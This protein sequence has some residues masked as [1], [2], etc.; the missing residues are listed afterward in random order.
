MKRL[1]LTLI[2]IF[3][4]LFST[5]GQQGFS[6]EFGKVWKADVEL[7]QYSQDKNAEAVVLF[8]VAT[9]HSERVAD[10]YEIVYE[11]TTR[12]KILSEAGIDWAE[13]E[14]PY[15]LEGDIYE[16]VTRIEAYSYIFENGHINKT[17][18]DISNVYTEKINDYWNVKKFAIPNVKPGSIIEYK[19]RINSQYMFNLRDWEF[20][21]KIPVVHSEYKVKLI[22]F[23][24]YEYI[25][26]GANKFD[27]FSSYLDK[28]LERHIGVCS[29]HDVVN[30]FVMEDVPAFKGEEFI[31]SINDYLI[32]VDFQLAK[33]NR[34]NGSSQEIMTTWEKLNKDILKNQD[35]GKYVNKSEK[36][37][38][39]LINEKDFDSKTEKEKFNYVLEY[40][41]NNY[42]W[43]GHTG[44]YASKSP[45][46]FIQEKHG[47]SADIN[48]FTA[49]LLRS[50]GI[51]TYP[52]LI[53]TRQH[54][55]I[56]YD[57]PFT[58][59][60]N[61]VIILASV[62]GV[63][64]L[65]DATDV[66]CL[67]DRIPTRCINDKGLIVKKDNV[68]WIKPIF[69]TPSEV[70]TEIE[71]EKVTSKKIIARISK[72]STEYDALNYRNSYGEK[73]DEIKKSLEKK[74]YTIDD[75]DLTVKNQR[76]KEKPY[77][78]SY[79]LSKGIENFNEK[80]YISPFLEEVISDN[81][82]KQ[83]TRTYPIDM[84]YPTKRKYLTTIPIPDGYGVDYVPSTQ[85]VSN[86]LFDL[87][88]TASH[89]DKQITVSLNYYFKKPVYSTRDYSKIKSYF[90]VIVKKGNEKIVLSKKMPEK[91]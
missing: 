33:V 41:K 7:K 58:H 23:Y 21:W 78:L 25:L 47:N 8:D 82:L 42:N 6:K 1:H 34:M 46:K 44:K 43:D 14:I 91:K 75:T 13:V 40:V 67:N 26:Q 64:I 87:T 72:T 62:D 54:G 73:L 85:K 24:E 77:I 4:T 20:Q 84:V 49:G 37:G 55:K 57:Y 39:K 68:E 31:S 38:A 10:W 60:F 35:F 61:Y 51:E 76:D 69:A 3:L 56:K 48:L 63:K 50:A 28:G 81:P 22:P 70:N 2:L 52:V 5:Y 12:I 27:S 11:R 15:Y 18:F 65:T 79:K 53:S 71:I 9:S 36:L 16:E 30:E 80:I 89:D 90:S 32:K 86:P 19:Y 59:F 88:Y 83:K 66:L 45:N 17:K 74:N 29:F